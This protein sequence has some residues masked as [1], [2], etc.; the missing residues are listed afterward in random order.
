MRSS[1]LLAATALLSL[2]GQNSKP[3]ADPVKV[4]AD[5]DGSWTGTFVGYDAT[6][7]EL[8]RIQVEH[9]YQTIDANVQR[10]R[11]RDQFADGQVITG[12]GE[13][14]AIRAANGELSLQCTVS[15]SNGEKVQHL[16]R[17]IAGPKG[18]Q[19]LVWHSQHKDSIET[20]REWVTGTGADAIYHIQGMGKYG[21]SMILMAGEYH[22]MAK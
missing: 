13:N 22:R 19:Q 1:L 11:T 17:L 7:R 10:V 18:R 3:I 4:F 14:R 15:K 5:L 2:C 16:G 12:E 6:G 8:Y 9:H 20:F 21:D